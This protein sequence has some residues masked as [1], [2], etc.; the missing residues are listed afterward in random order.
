M[1]WIDG[2]ILNGYRQNTLRARFS[3]LWS[4]RARRSVRREV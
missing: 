2:T 1:P 4:R 3:R